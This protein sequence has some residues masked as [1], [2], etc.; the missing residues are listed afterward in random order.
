[1]RHYPTA[2]QEVVVFEPVV[3]EDAR[4]WFFESFR[5]DVFDSA[6]A[7]PW[8]FV[9]DNHS[10]SSAGVV[11]GLHYQLPPHPQGKLVR[12]VVGSILDV[13]VDI[14]RSSPTFGRWVAVPLS[15]TDK[16]QLWIPPGFAHGFV[17]YADGTEIVYKT[18][19]YYAPDCERSLQWNDPE[20]GV[21][22]P[23][24]LLLTA[25]T[26]DSLAPP[27]SGAELFP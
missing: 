21:E 25:S 8:T 16:R 22:W 19:D 27:L 2:L 17:A 13:A 14:R 10:R 5:K 9:Q 12:V 3:H 11:R 20:L 7:G 23:H 15:A 18:T 24:E 4:G 1:V 26:K 6:T